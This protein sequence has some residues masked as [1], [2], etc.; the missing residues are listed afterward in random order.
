MFTPIR[1]TII[2]LSILLLAT[3]T[4]V[5]ACKNSTEE[6]VKKAGEHEIIMHFLQDKPYYS[7]SY[8]RYMFICGPQCKGCTTNMLYR[9]D[10]LYLRHKQIR[11]IRFITSHDFVE[12]LGL[13][14]IVFTYDESWENVN[15]D[16]YNIRWYELSDT[17]IIS[18]TI[19]TADNGDAFVKK[20]LD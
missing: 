7:D 12:E 15:I 19:L 6:T 17:S 4:M 16:F 10:S 8:K 13:E 1:N 3:I 14:N 9:L 5:Y 20:V 2:P 11:K 18:K